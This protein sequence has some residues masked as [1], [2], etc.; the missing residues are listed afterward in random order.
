MICCD[1]CQRVSFT[2]SPQGYFPSLVLKSAATALRPWSA[3]TSKDVHGMSAPMAAKEAQRRAQL[4]AKARNIT[5]MNAS[6]SV[7]EP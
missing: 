3:V 1:I 6:G 4:L 5:K 2:D 7:P